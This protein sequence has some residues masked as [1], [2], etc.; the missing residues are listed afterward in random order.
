MCRVALTDHILFPT[1]SNRTILLLHLPISPIPHHTDR[2]EVRVKPGVHADPNPSAPDA[3]RFQ[4]AVSFMS[5]RAM[6]TNHFHP[7][8]LEVAEEGATATGV[9]HAMLVVYGS[10]SICMS[11][12]EGCTLF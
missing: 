8:H 4:T 7:Y 3:G 1:I 11:R 9:Y 6:T 12:C 10:E 2:T 5:S